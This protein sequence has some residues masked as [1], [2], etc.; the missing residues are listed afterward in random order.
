MKATTR[1]DTGESGTFVYC[2]HGYRT[3][4]GHQKILRII[5]MSANNHSQSVLEHDVIYISAY[6]IGFHTL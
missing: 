4:D 1:V 3:L 2:Q 5:T 6:F